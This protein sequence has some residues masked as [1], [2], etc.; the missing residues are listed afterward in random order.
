MCI[1][2]HTL[3]QVVTHWGPP[4]PYRGL[5]G[6]LCRCQAEASLCLLWL[7]GLRGKSLLFALCTK[8]DFLNTAAKSKY[9]NELVAKAIYIWPSESDI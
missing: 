9:R 6:G 5:L 8:Q 7:R 4:A 2:E 3:G 1:F